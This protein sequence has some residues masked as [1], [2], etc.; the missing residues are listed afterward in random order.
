MVK[1]GQELLLTIYALADH[2]Y[3]VAK[4]GRDQVYVKQALPGER[5]RVIITKKQKDG[6]RAKVKEYLS[7]HPQRIQSPCQH[8]ALCGSC[9]L[10]HVRYPAQ[11]S[12]KQ[13]QVKQW[14]RTAGLSLNV[15]EVIGMKHPYGYR[16]KVII[17]FQRGEH[18][19]LKAGF[20]EE[21][22]H[23]IIPYQRCLLHDELLDSIIQT[24]IVLMDRF[25]ITPYEEDRRR[26]ILRHVVLRKGEVSH[27]LMV[28]LVVNQDEFKARRQFVQA[29][30]QQYPQ[31]TTIVQSTNTR[32]TSVVLGSRM[33]VLYGKGYI[34]D[35]LCGNQ[36]RISANSFYQIN[37]TQCEV[38][39][40]KVLSLLAPKGD[41]VLL[42]AY[43]GIG[44]IG[45]SVAHQVR[46]VVGVENN[47]AAVRDAWDNAKRN[48]IRNIRFVCADASEFMVQEAGRK[49]HYDILIMDPPRSGSTKAF[50]DACAKLAVSKI[51]YVS[52]DPKT[53]LRDLAYFRQLGYVGEEMFLV[54]MFPHTMHVETVVLMS[55]REK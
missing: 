34:E 48:H 47:A 42:D 41:E 19:R 35:T 55:R 29:L 8:D 10:M 25:H 50:M 28:V 49:A 37:H 22:S 4:V 31:I 32:K 40:Q 11:L 38:L 39:Y 24:M 26:G 52:C 18:H 20:Y 46:A 45:M 33:R 6:Y 14:C 3:G 16:N 9:H 7:V 30:C 54:D 5:C 43:C 23:R 21:F 27:Q 15:H 51:V 36:F 44:T 12:M 2:G 1:V 13:E 17:A 53:Q